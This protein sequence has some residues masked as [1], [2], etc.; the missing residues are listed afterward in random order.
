MYYDQLLNHT[1][2]TSE[3]YIISL[4]QNIDIPTARFHSKKN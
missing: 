1:V 2:K 3:C 4:K